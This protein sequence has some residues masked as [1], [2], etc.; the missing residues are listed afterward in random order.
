MVTWLVSL[1]F[2]GNDRLEKPV[3]MRDTNQFI[4]TNS[5]RYRFIFSLP[6]NSDFAM[7]IRKPS[8]LGALLVEVRSRPY[9]DLAERAFP[10]GLVVVRS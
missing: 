9:E 3:N 1:Y 4:T 7:Y 10:S 6:V 5:C 8:I 2:L